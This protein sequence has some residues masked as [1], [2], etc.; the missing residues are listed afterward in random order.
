[1][2]HKFVHFWQS[3]VVNHG[4]QEPNGCYSQQSVCLPEKNAKSGTD[5]M[6]RTGLQP[7]KYQE[8]KMY[9]TIKTQGEIRSQIM[10]GR[11]LHLVSVFLML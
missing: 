10:G 7:N 3:K 4:L 8:R 9:S 2:G 1:M 11:G 6:K 5:K